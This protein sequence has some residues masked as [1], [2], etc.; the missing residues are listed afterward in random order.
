MGGNRQPYGD[1]SNTE[2]EDIVVEYKDKEDYAILKDPIA[3]GGTFDDRAHGW[4]MQARG[5]NL[6]DDGIYYKSYTCRTRKSGGVV[7][8]VE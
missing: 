8:V 4:S 1:W 2:R 5:F 7:T 3:Y 6:V